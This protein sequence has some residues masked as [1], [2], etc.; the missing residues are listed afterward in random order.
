[1]YPGTRRP[2]KLARLYM[3]IENSPLSGFPGIV[4]QEIF[5]LGT[6]GRSGSKTIQARSDRYATHC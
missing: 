3:R 5:H 4:R 6:R 2:G 1:M